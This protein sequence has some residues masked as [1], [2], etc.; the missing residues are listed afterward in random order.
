MKYIALC[1]SV[2]IIGLDQLFKQL[3]IIY[4]KT[5]IT[6]PVI[7][8][9]FH[10]TYLENRGAAFGILDGK[11]IFLIVMTCIIIV[12]GIFVILTNKIKSKFLLWSIAA[13]VGGGMGNLI[14]RIFRGFVVDY[15]D[16]RIINFAVFN[17]ADCC[18]VIGTIMIMFYI[19][20]LDKKPKPV[21]EK[22]PKLEIIVDD[23]PKENKEKQGKY[24]AVISA[25][26]V[27]EQKT[28]K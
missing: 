12:A 7:E 8:D 4:L 2:F 15:L 14:D 22:K 20:F 25:E 26:E 18:V 24:I 23:L 13:V 6:V 9:F 17:F 21:E 19:L 11:G 1:F 16:F 5:E 10:F 27:P 28:E 3:A